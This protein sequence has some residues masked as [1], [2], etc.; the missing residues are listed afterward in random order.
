MRTRIRVAGVAGV[1]GAVT[2]W[3]STVELFLY[4]SNNTW[5]LVLGETFVVILRTDVPAVRVQDPPKQAEG[6]AG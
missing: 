5:D 3:Y 6:R 2:T 1:R 4:V